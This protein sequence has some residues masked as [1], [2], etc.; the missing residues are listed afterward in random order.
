[1]SD[2]STS[3][4]LAAYR[5]FTSRRGLVKTLYSDNGT[6][7]RGA[8]RELRKMFDTAS[9]F[10][11]GVAGTLAND[12]T[13]WEFIPPHSPHFGGLWEAGIKSTKHHLIR[14]IGESTLTFEEFSTVLAE[15]EACLNSRP[16][17]PLSSDVEDLDALTPAHFLVGGPLTLVP[18]APPPTGPDSRLSRFQGLQRMRQV[19]WKRWSQEYLHHLQERGKW[20]EP[21]DNFAVGQL[22]LVKDERYPPTKWPLGRVTEVH[23]G[24]D[25]LVRVVTVRLANTTLRR[26]IVR[27]SPLPIRAMPA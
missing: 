19:F 2:L 24:S 20:R 14:V 23:P 17:C 9:E 11:A 13:S 12:G 4:F 3:S 22:V 21:S 25:G 15:I 6:T 1:M 16:L 18:E 27:L 7:F 26:P 10:Y 8:D 5:R